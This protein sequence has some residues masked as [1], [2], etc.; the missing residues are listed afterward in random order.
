MAERRDRLVQSFDVNYML[1]PETEIALFAV[2]LGVQC[3]SL[4][5]CRQFGLCWTFLRR[6]LHTGMFAKTCCQIWTVHNA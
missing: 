3:Q 5:F 4:V 2:T 1:L 6:S